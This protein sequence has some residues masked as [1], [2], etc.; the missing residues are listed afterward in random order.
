MRYY[1]CWNINQMTSKNQKKWGFYPQPKRMVFLGPALRPMI[2]G[3]LLNVS[4]KSTFSGFGS[5][6]WLSKPAGKSRLER[7]CLH[8]PRFFGEDWMADGKKF[9]QDVWWF[10]KLS[11]TESFHQTR[12]LNCQKAGT[13]DFEFPKFC[14]SSSS[15]SS[16]NFSLVETLF[17]SVEQT[18]PATRDSRLSAIEVTRFHLWTGSRN[19]TGSLHV[20]IIWLQIS[21]KKPSPE[22]SVCF[23]G[24]H[25]NTNLSWKML[26]SMATTWNRK[27]NKNHSQLRKNLSFSFPKLRSRP[28]SLH[29][30]AIPNSPLEPF[31]PLMALEMKH[32]KKR[33]HQVI[34]HSKVAWTFYIFLCC[35]LWTTWNSFL[36]FNGCCIKQSHWISKT[37]VSL[38]FHDRKDQRNSRPQLVLHDWVMPAKIVQWRYIWN[39]PIKME[40]SIIPCN[41]QQVRVHRS[42]VLGFR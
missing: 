38:A 5:G 13:N 1:C 37:S 12:E 30:P 24:F 35:K 34:H 26:T 32:G 20:P 9:R 15:L 16:S 11:T 41:T 4:M 28:N 33:W 22:V 40:D 7:S 17:F 23:F 21:T 27:N 31:V 29:L 6:F 19:N 3:F 36:P 42:F 14:S 10:T 2:P 18:P 39:I 25:Q 8:L